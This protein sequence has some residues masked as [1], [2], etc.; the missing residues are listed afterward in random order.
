MQE[1]DHFQ[2]LV[3]YVERNAL[4]AGLVE[5]AED[6]EWGSLWDRWHGLGGASLL[7]AWPLSCP[8]DWVERFNAAQSA[9]EL[10]A[11]RRSIQRGRPYGQEGWAEQTARRLRLG[12]SLRPLG[13]PRKRPAPPAVPEQRGLFD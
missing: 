13:R 5:R 2:A 7:S 11:I 8:D 6:W 1:D 10:E 12:Q 3:R 4:R 9:A